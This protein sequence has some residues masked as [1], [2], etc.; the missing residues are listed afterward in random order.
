MTKS[1]VSILIPVYNAVDFL[2]QC[3]QSVLS[4]T[5]TSLQIVMVDD[6]STDGSWH[7][8]QKYAAQDNR[9]EIYHQENQGVAVTRNHLLE[10]IKGE[11]VLFIDADD[12]IESDMVEFL[13]SKIN[14]TQVDI[15][16]CGNVVNDEPISNKYSETFLTQEKTIERFLYHKELRGSLWNKLIK[17]SLLH[18]CRFHCGRSLG[19]DALFFWHVLQNTNNILFTDRQLYHYRLNNDSICHSVFGPRKLSAH[20]VWEQICNETEKNHCQ[21][22]T[23]AKAR[24]CIE[25]VL[26]LRDAVKSRYPQKSEIKLLQST[27]S[28]NWPCLFEVQITSLKMKLFA[29]VISKF[30]GIAK[31]F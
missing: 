19:E 27:I 5:Y 13:I 1:I 31:F 18:N 9:I 29:I 7:V 25:D 30:S 14:D 17:T 12:W 8:L 10:K 16:T 21:Y 23:I 15:V 6:G 28:H 11:Y 24:H 22:L 26:L 3:I 2:S 4:Q 20:Y